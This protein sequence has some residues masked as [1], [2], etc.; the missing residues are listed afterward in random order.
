RTTRSCVRSRVDPPAPYVTETNDGASD[1]SDAIVRNNSS[2]ASSVFGGKNSKLNVVRCAAKMS[3]MCMGLPDYIR[4]L[5]VD[6]WR[7][8]AIP[9]DVQPGAAE[10]QQ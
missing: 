2:L 4:V 1:C 10:V 9:F 5:R 6:P 8:S 3:W 7:L